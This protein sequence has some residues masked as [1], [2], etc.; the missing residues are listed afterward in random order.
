MNRLAKITLLLFFFALCGGAIVATH[1]ARKRTPAPAAKDLYSIV[2]QQLFALQN[3]D[4]ASAYRQA[5]SGVQEKFS[6][7]QFEL[8]IR[9]DF[10]S[11]REAHRV[12]FGA[13][14]VTGATAIVQVFLTMPNGAMRGFLYSFTAEGKSWKIDGVQ[15]LGPQ[16]LRRLR[17]LHV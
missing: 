13:V 2:N 14:Q 4:F 3:D 17:G 1:L 8:M 12:E 5:A 16:P 6:Q 11:M 10:W 15:P 7:A 9:R